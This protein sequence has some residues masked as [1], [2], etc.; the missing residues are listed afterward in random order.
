MAWNKA[1]TTARPAAI[2]ALFFNPYESIP[3]RQQKRHYNRY[4]KG[5]N[6]N[7]CNLFYHLYIFSNAVIKRDMYY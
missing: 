6:R 3:F 2:N 5:K 4:C 1:A 7:F